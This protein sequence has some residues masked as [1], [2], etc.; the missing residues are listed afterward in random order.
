[1]LSDISQHA[2]DIAI[3]SLNSGAKNICASVSHSSDCT[4]LEISDDGCGIDEPLLSEIESSLDSPPS[5]NSRNGLKSLFASSEGRM[6]IT[7]E[8]GVG[9]TIFATFSKDFPTGDFKETAKCLF[10]LC[11]AQGV[12]FVLLTNGKRFDSEEFISNTETN[13]IQGA[14]LYKLLDEC[15]T[16]STKI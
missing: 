7:S 1:M 15:L 4:A 10:T 3:N 9:T 16:I 12:R 6:K 8:K 2:L 14:K 5:G 11:V 13:G